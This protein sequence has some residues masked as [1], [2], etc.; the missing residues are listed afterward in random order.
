MTKRIVESLSSPLPALS[1]HG[2][3]HKL[4][5]KIY[6]PINESDKSKVIVKSEFRFFLQAE[7]ISRTNET[8]FAHTLFHLINSRT[9]NVNGFIDVIALFIDF[10][11]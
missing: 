4:L 7:S 11:V 2:R 6:F 8:I 1:T 9:R 3:A 5:S 10:A